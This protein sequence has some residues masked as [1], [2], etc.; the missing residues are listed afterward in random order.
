[1]TKD[2]RKAVQF[3]LKHPNGWHSHTTDKRTV[4]LVCSLVN[5]GIAQVSNVSDQFRLY[6]ETHAKQFLGIV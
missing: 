4:E 5:L 6:S 2:Q 3:L 1:M